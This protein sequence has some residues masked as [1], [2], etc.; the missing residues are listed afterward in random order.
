[1]IME[2]ASAPAGQAGAGG[3][4]VGYEDVSAQRRRE[5]R[6]F[7]IVASY[8]QIAPVSGHD[9]GRELLGL[10]GVLAT[11]PMGLM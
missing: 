1:M 11:L 2:R 4:P 6:D 10:E 8:R 5:S 3:A 7:M 9:H